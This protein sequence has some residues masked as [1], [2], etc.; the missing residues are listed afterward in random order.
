MIKYE[1]IDNFLNDSDFTKLRDNI[2][3]TAI[4]T[5]KNLDLWNYIEGAGQLCL[6]CGRRNNKEAEHAQKLWKSMID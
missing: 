1:V 2:S 6:D 3:P 4:G 5:P